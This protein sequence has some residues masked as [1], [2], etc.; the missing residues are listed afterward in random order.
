MLASMVDKDKEDDFL[1][2]FLGNIGESSFETRAAVGAEV[3][4]GWL[5]NGHMI[6]SRLNLGNFGVNFLTPPNFTQPRRQRLL[7]CDF[8]L[9]H[10]SVHF[11]FLVADQ[12]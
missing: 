3:P 12:I 2:E 7:S 9:L 8:F 11:W 4:S 10:A 1:G 5:I 6:E